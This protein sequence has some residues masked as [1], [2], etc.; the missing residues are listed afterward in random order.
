MPLSVSTR[1]TL[2]CPSFLKRVLRIRLLG[3]VA[4]PRAGQSNSCS[5]RGILSHGPPRSICAGDNVHYSY[6]RVNAVCTARTMQIHVCNLYRQNNAV[7]CVSF[8][9]GHQC[10]YT[11]I[12]CTG[13]ALL[14]HIISLYHLYSENNAVTHI[15]FVLGEQCSYTCIICRARAMQLNMYNLYESNAVTD[16]SFVRE[17]R[18]YT[19]IIC[20][21][22][23]MQLH[24]YN[25]YR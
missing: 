16:V 2:T 21:A 19:C 11:C 23:A 17:Q 14:L 22:R 15:L 9:Y 10:S 6:T 1:V 3:L 13:T 5:I 25:L 24:T 20:T 8:V 12:I 7:T 4:P 18:S